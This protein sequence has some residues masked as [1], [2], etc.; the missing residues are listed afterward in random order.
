MRCFNFILQLS[1][2]ALLGMLLNG[3]FSTT[4]A[5]TTN[6]V[7][8][9][10]SPAKQKVELAAGRSYTGKFLLQNLGKTAFNYRLKATP[11]QAINEQYDIDYATPTAR[12]QI[13]RWISFQEESV[14]LQPG[15]AKTITYK[16]TAPKDAPAG[17]QYAAI[18]ASALDK[19]Q[20]SALVQITNQVGLVVYARI[21]GETK[22]EGKIILNNVST[23]YL[24]EPFILSSTVENKGNVELDAKLEATIT[25]FFSNRVVYDNNKTPAIATILPD[26]KRYNTITW[27]AAPKLGLFKVRQKISL[28]KES[29]VVEKIVLVCPIWLVIAVGF[30]VLFAV[31][32]LLLRLT[33]RRSR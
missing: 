3:I 20:G 26:T 18:M 10:I 31:F 7:D 1:G 17:G 30:L 28:L 12:T 9:Q 6:A 19:S 27:E 16:I 29:S 23:V 32:W 14:R 33:K 21:A 5:A 22:E 8:I 25:D 24:S 4:V 13:A 2:M 15:Q 11:F